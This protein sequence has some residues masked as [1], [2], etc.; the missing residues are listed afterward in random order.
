MTATREVLGNHRRQSQE[1][2]LELGLRLSL[3]LRRAN[4]SGLFP[5]TAATESVTFCDADQILAGSSRVIT[6]QFENQS[7]DDGT[8]AGDAHF[9]H[10]WRL[11]LRRPY[12]KPRVDAGIKRW[13]SPTQR[14]THAL[15][16]LPRQKGT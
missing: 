5:H 2:R 11:G 12:F 10:V 13:P 7:S 15:C 1:T 14:K 16:F 4:Q 8:L 6:R 9:V 3:G